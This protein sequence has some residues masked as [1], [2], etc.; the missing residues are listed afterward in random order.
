MKQ[1][2]IAYCIYMPTSVQM[3][4]YWNEDYEKIWFII[5]AT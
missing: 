3:A 2:N 5:F 4:I 1:T